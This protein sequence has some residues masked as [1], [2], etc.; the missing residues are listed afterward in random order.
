MKKITFMLLAGLFLLSCKKENKEQEVLGEPKITSISPEKG[1][2]L[3]VLTIEGENFSRL[4]VNNHV[5]ING[6][7]ARIIHF[8]EHTIHV[9]VPEGGST[10]EVSVTVGTRPVKGPVFT[11]MEPPPVYEI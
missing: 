7:D 2:P 5:Q 4:R 6:V 3:S 11:Y 1:F 8:N 9:E 10:G